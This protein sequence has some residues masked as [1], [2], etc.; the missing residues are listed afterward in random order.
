MLD[1]PP[2]LELEDLDE[3]RAGRAGLARRVDMQDHVVAVGEDALDVGM[4]VGEF[5][6]EQRDQR[7]ETLWAVRRG[8]VVLD[9]TRPEIFRCGVVVLLVEGFFIEVDDDFLVGLEVGGGRR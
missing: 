5:F 1:D 7:L 9:V 3:R 8:G 4:G 2:V 6:L